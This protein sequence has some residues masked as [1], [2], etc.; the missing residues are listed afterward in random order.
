VNIQVSGTEQDVSRG[1]HLALRHRELVPQRLQPIRIS[2]SGRIQRITVVSQR[3]DQVV[4]I[5]GRRGKVPRI[6]ILVCYFGQLGDLDV[7]SPRI[8]ADVEKAGIVRLQ[9]GAV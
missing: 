1:F 8:S 2:T 7:K 3:L 5:Q 4:Q 9:N 6:Q